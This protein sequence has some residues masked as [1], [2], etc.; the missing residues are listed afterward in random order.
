MK[1]KLKWRS[2]FDPKIRGSIENKVSEDKIKTK[3]NATADVKA[4]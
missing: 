2:I 1:E 4:S 3:N